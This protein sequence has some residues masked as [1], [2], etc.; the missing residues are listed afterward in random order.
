MADENSIKILLEEY[1]ALWGYY[2]CQINVLAGFRELYIKI[3]FIPVTV[4]STAS[5]ALLNI[6]ATAVK[7]KPESILWSL[8][9]LLI[10]CVAMGIALFVRYYKEL[11]NLGNYE[12]A[13]IDIRHHLWRDNGPHAISPIDSH[14]QAARIGILANSHPRTAFYCSQLYSLGA[15]FIVGNSALIS[16]LTCTIISALALSNRYTVWSVWSCVAVGSF[17]FICFSL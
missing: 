16:L 7:V 1:K 12:Q 14:R 10:I 11:G 17:A 3:F 9:V 13:M 2:I 6:F 4:V 5:V 8:T 15:I